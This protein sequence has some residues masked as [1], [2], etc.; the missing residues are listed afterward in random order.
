MF[1]FFKKEESQKLTE[2]CQLT[3]IELQ[4]LLSNTFGSDVSLEQKI[5]DH[6]ICDKL[7]DLLKK[8]DKLLFKGLENA[9]IDS[10][11][12]LDS[13][14][15]IN[16]HLAIGKFLEVLENSEDKSHTLSNIDD[17]VSL[18]FVEGNWN[19]DK[20]KY[21]P[22]HVKYDKVISFDEILKQLMTK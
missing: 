8:Q 16:S 15:E 17:Q 19:D 22:P 12:I 6:Y 13:I 7:V 14:N 1:N 10:T 18:E 4:I 2:A 21:F 11:N 9:G 3:A 20:S 5:V